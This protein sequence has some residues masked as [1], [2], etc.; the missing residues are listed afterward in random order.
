[1]VVEVLRLPAHSRA[2]LS[3]LRRPVSVTE[4]Q[5]LVQAAVSPVIRGKIRNILS[6]RAQ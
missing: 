3:E 2:G 6:T 5:H 1:M 4:G